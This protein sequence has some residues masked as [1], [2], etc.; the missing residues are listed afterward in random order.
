MPKLEL[1]PF[2]RVLKGDLEPTDHQR[3]FLYIPLPIFR[4]YTNIRDIVIKHNGRRDGK[5]LHEIA[6]KH[7]IQHCHDEMGKLDQWEKLH[8]DELDYTWLASD[9][10]QYVN[11]NNIQLIFFYFICINKNHTF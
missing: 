1:E 7:K 8:L 10:Q 3:R 5:A 11:I 4:D 6:I 9:V 2:R